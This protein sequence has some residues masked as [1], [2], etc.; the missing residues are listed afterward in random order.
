MN[1]SIRFLTLFL[2]LFI[3]LHS[4]GQDLGPQ[5][6][7]KWL[8]LK[9]QFQKRSKVVNK[10][11]KELSKSNVDKKQTDNLKNAVFALSNHLNKLS[12]VDSLSI[13][14]V[15]VKN[16][17]LIQAIQQALLAI[18]RQPTLKS[19]RTFSDLQMQLEGCENQIAVAVNDYNS[20]CKK[21]KR[22]DL[23]FHRTNQTQATEV[24]F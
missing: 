23:V 4:F 11:T 13:S 6:E 8:D 5:I 20:T 1:F 2:F 19:T 21:Y 24:K 15:E 18:E 3:A 9:T 22:T 14:L 17:N 10:L 7:V 16:M 12:S